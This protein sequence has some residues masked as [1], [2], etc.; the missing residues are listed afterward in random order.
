MTWLPVW[1]RAAVITSAQTF[2]GTFLAL[3]LAMVP[4]ALDW[5]NGGAIPDLATY[6]KLL[7]A[8]F[9]AFITGVVTAAYRRVKPIGTDYP[10]A[11]PPTTAVIVV[12]GTDTAENP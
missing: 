12:D 6:A 7:A 10:D 1:L 8:A 3:L 9:A 2:I 11:M 4:D 5:V